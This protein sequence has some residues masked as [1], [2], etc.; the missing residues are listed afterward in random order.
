MEGPCFVK[1]MFSAENSSESVKDGNV[2]VQGQHISATRIYQPTNL[3][4]NPVLLET[5]AGL[6]QKLFETSSI[7]FQKGPAQPP[8]LLKF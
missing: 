4:S 7:R 2:T 3:R 8:G 6:T 1:P 5:D